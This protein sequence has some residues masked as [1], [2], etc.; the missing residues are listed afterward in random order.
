MNTASPPKPKTFHQVVF[1]ILLFVLTSGCSSTDMQGTV[2]KADK[3]V[4][5]G[6]IDEAI[7]H[8]QRA[9]QKHPKESVLYLNQAAL[10]RRKERYFNA[11]RNY[12]VVLKLNPESFWPYIG[13]AR[14]YL[15]QKKYDNARK[16][17]KKGLKEI[18][19]N[20]PILFYLGKTYYEV[21]D[22]RRAVDYL[23][24]ALDAKY[25]RLDRIYYYRGLAHDNL[26]N[27]RD[28][29]KMDFESFLLIAKDD[30][31]KE[32]IQKRL[33]ELDVNRYDF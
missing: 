9:I 16:I 30:T 32:Q 2:S 13:L 29:A 3:L 31:D 15:A 17:L 11:I 12:Q 22:G 26:L 27:N 24:R 7:V 28:Q 1:S 25:K 23:T 33:N 6:Q 10:F 18:P 4:A 19:D 14:V 8:Y 21:G 20:G 5:A